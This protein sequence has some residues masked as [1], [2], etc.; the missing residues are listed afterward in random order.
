MFVLL[1]EGSLYISVKELCCELFAMLA[2]VSSKSA[3]KVCS[4]YAGCVLGRAAMS[5]VG[6][7]QFRYISVCLFSTR[8]TATMRRAV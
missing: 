2:C 4:L 1:W 5:D 7:V 3:R 8:M 6:K